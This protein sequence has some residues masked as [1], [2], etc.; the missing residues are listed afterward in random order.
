MKNK[1]QKILILIT[2]L[3]GVNT[4]IFSQNC[5]TGDIILS[6]QADVDNFVATYSGTCDTIDG[7][8]TI[9][10]VDVVDVSGLSFLKTVSGFLSI[11]NTEIT[12]T[13]GL[14]NIIDVNYFY[15]SYNLSLLEYDFPSLEST[16]RIQVRG[17]SSMTS[18]NFPS[19]NSISGSIT[20]SNN[21]DL[22]LSNT[23]A[24]VSF[25][26]LP[27][28]TSINLSQL[29]NTARL[30]LDSLPIIT[31]INFD[32]LISTN[33]SIEIR[34]TTSLPTI[35][36]PKLTNIIGF[37]TILKIDNND[38]LVTINFP[39][40][41]NIDGAH[42]II[43]NNEILANLDGLSSLKYARNI[44]ISDNTNLTSIEGLDNLEAVLGSFF[45]S[46]NPLLNE[47][48]IL[49]NFIN[50]E[51]YVGGTLTI[52]ANGTN[53]NSSVDVILNCNISQ[54][55]IDQD[56]I[57]DSVDNCIS[58]SNPNQEDLDGD[59]VG[60]DCDNCPDDANALQED[61][62]NNGIGNACEASG[63]GADAGSDAGGLGIG[64]SN[65]NSQFEIAKGDVFIKNMHRG[66]IM[67]A[68]NGKCFRV[69]PNN[70]GVLKSTEITC[71]DN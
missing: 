12:T 7:H 71:P 45:V 40:L 32:N 51:N 56:T 36:F 28:L 69:Q 21:V 11:I 43:T 39:V 5:S 41:N 53:C 3:L 15:M 17:A 6:S 50:G 67:K 34:F 38:A 48:C 58:V 44:T 30:F 60:D 35:N 13:N 65:P 16:T 59:G 57:I 49:Q 24:S 70:E 14:H 33:D 68:P 37:N 29:T 19:L 66:V 64:T 8:L 52:S 9:K 42:I 62:N 2:L 54:V 1:L 55:D 22:E 4:I 20:V 47:C 25:Y 26:N 61:A 27:N 46:N 10:N 63:I 18:F 23:V 31:S